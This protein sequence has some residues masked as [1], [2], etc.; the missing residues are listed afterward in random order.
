MKHSY[1]TAIVQIGDQ[2]ILAHDVEI[3]ANWHPTSCYDQPFAIVHL[4][5]EITFSGHMWVS[6]LLSWVVRRHLLQV[7]A[8]PPPQG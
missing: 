8:L 2:R 1:D 4:P 7:P 3:V 6:P 5:E